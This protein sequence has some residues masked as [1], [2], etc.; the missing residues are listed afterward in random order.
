VIEYVRGSYQALRRD[1]QEATFKMHATSINGS[2]PA[3]QE[4]G[5]H[6]KKSKKD[7]KRLREDDDPSVETESKRHKKSK[8]HTESEIDG[9]E[10]NIHTEPTTHL[11]GKDSRKKKKKKEKLNGVSQD[12]VTAVDDVSASIGQDNEGEKKSKKKKKKSKHETE[13]HEVPGETEDRIAAIDPEEDETPKEQKK[14][15]R[16]RKKPQKEED[17]EAIQDEVEVQDDELS[18]KKKRKEKKA[19]KLKQAEDAE[20]PEEKDQKTEKKEK[21]KKKMRKSDD[22]AVEEMDIDKPETVTTKE[23]VDILDDSMFPFYTQ[24]I[25]LYVPFYPVG[26]DKPI[27]NVVGQH[28]QPLLNHYSPLLRG[29]P[30]AYHNVN[31]SERPE[32][33]DPN[34]LPTDMTGAVLS[35][36]DEYAV[37]FG[38]LTADMDLFVPS[39]G[40]VMEGIVNLQSEGHIGVV[41]WGKFNASIEAKRLPPG[42]R[43][44]DLTNGGPRYKF[45]A[46]GEDE[47]DGE[48]EQEEDALDGEHLE[49]GQMHT[50]GYW[51]DGDGRRAKQLRFR[52]KNFD[53]GLAGDYGYLSIEGTM[54]DDDQERA[55][56]DEERQ[57]ER[58]RRSR[59]NP[60]GLLRP[61]SRRVPEFSVTKFGREPEEEDSAKRVEIYRGSRPPTPN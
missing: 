17:P 28:L 6:K 52:I 19:K 14:R 13:D 54:L 27:T 37:G 36:V 40:A 4:N 33:A 55:L 57:L 48:D 25:S 10:V 8:K 3:V 59:Q 44:N 9:A 23:G 42:W 18:G 45:K 39:R 53:V 24:T 31:L 43:W 22:A 46:L 47:A 41:C 51:V 29:V 58:D 21:K 20:E 32:R 50:T 30:L 61:L 49:L 35:S 56:V 12:A 15:K 34:N 7:K 38:W 16:R 26:F 5:G 2:S 1:C 60:Q 11:A